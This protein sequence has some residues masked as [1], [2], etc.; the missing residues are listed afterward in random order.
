MLC[1]IIH[2]PLILFFQQSLQDVEQELASVRGELQRVNGMISVK[3]A[4][5]QEQ[6][7]QLQMTEMKVNIR[8][9]MHKRVRPDLGEI[10]FCQK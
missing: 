4:Q 10:Y 9:C 5:I 3:E 1:H 7:R 2:K 8:V 6:D